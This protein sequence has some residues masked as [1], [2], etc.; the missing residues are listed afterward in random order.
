MALYGPI[1][2][3]ASN[4]IHKWISVSVFCPIKGNM[5]NL[6]NYPAVLVCACVCMR[7]LSLFNFESIHPDLDE[8]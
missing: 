3:D 2:I 8:A 6:L 4:K 1:T 5:L 7:V